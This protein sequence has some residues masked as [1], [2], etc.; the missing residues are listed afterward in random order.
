MTNS[1][2][3]MN[4]GFLGAGGKLVIDHMFLSYSHPYGHKFKV[5]SKDVETVIVDD[6]GWGKAKLKIIG[7]GTELASAK[8]PIPWANKCQEWIL[9]NK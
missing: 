1:S 5:P 7:R 2:K 4:I 8:M 9:E 6:I 3:K